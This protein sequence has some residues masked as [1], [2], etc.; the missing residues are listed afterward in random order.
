MNV[1]RK[2]VGGALA[3]VAAAGLVF[4]T[5]A[6]AAAHVSPHKH[7]LVTPDGWVI[8]AEGVSEEAPND[9]ALENLHYKVHLGVP[10]GEPLTI[11]RVNVNQDCSHLPLP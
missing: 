9:P 8:I 3:A 10:G 6:P 5:T 2:I 4:A 1:G 11:V 7:C